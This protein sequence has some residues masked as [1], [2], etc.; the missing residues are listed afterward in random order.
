MSQVISIANQKGGVGKT[1]TALNLSFALALRGKKTLLIDLDPQGSATSGLGV[2]DQ[3]GIYQ[4][5]M[6]SPKNPLKN[7]IVKTTNPCLNLVPS[8]PDLAGAEME[9]ANSADRVFFLK[10]IVVTEIKKSYD[11]ILIDT[12]PS[13]GLLSLNA[14]SAGDS[15]IVPL[16]CEY[17]ALEGLGRLLETAREVRERWNPTLKLQ[18]I[19]LTLFDA[20]NSL[21]YQVEKE[22]RRH[23][24]DQVFETLIPRN[25]RL[26]EAPGFGKSVFQYAPHCLG[27]MAYEQLAQELEKKTLKAQTYKTAPLTKNLN[28]L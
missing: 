11:F 23:F 17:Y 19:L 1:T 24:G 25:V 3:E 10:K 7:F 9:L 5:L 20:R 21:S 16:Q 14:L 12:P 2:S 22:A 13:L 18:G 28:P 6:G 8:T 27:A 15:F 4:A 26:S